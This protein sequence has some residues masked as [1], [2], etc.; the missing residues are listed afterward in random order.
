[1]ARRSS[2]GGGVVLAA[3]AILGFLWSLLKY[4]VPTIIIA[5][6]ILTLIFYRDAFG[7]VFLISILVGVIY[8]ALKKRNISG[9]LKDDAAPGRKGDR[10]EIIQRY[11]ARLRRD[12]FPYY[13]E[14]QTR[15]CIRDIMMSEGVSAGSPRMGEYLSTWRARS[16][17]PQYYKDLAAAIESNFRNRLHELRAEEEKK[18]QDALD[19][20]VGRLWDQNRELIERF[21]EIAERKVSILDD[22]GDENWDAL[23]TEINAV[24]RKIAQK[25]GVTERNIQELLKKGYPWC[26]GEEYSI[27]R[28]KLDEEFRL[29]HSTPR[30][31]AH[32][33]NSMSGVEFETHI[34][35]GL[36]QKGYTVCGTPA[37]GDQG[38]DLIAMKNGRTIVIQAKRYSG[39]V[40]NR[41]VQEVISAKGGRRNKFTDSARW[42]S[43]RSARCRPA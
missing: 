29:R 20:K 13:V 19:E 31:Q 32:E 14:N 23:P 28:K 6:N 2:G 18:Q 41:A 24:L 11:F 39:P 7:A 3:A 1:M 34:A 4:P 26:V 36:Q 33:Y 9:Q 35:Q 38:A 8:F 43:S 27:L 16:D 22:Y 25:G 15:D 40:G 30:P 17:V 21:F 37:T 12:S 10:Q 42:C 5:V